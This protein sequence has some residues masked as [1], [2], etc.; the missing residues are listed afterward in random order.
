MFSS[1]QA[2]KFPHAKLHLALSKIF[3]TLLLR[4]LYLH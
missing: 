4:R 1:Q 2:P 3:S